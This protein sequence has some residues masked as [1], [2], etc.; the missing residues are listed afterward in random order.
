MADFDGIEEMH[1]IMDDDE[2]RWEFEAY[3]ADQ[4]PAIPSNQESSGST[5]TMTD[6]D[7]V[8]RNLDLDYDTIEKRLQIWKAG[9]QWTGTSMMDLSRSEFD[10]S[11]PWK[12]R[13]T[14]AKM[15]TYDVQELGPLIQCPKGGMT[16]MVDDI[17]SM[18]FGI[19]AYAINYHM[20][21]WSSF[22]HSDSTFNKSGI[23]QNVR[24]DIPMASGY[25]ERAGMMT[26]V[27]QT[28]ATV[29]GLERG[30]G[31]AKWY[32]LIVPGGSGTLRAINFLTKVCLDWAPSNRRN[33]RNRSSFNPR[34]DVLIDFGQ[35]HA[36]MMFAI[37]SLEAKGARV[38][39]PLRS[40]LQD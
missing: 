14:A 32:I 24:Y 8:D 21:A 18:V 19:S 16:L 40:R 5:G 1:R 17:N 12:N 29:E 26:A 31:L 35:L 9:G 38:L 39:L 7:G 2:L 13:E 10:A 30:R 25:Q 15:R 28:L 37:E 6:S 36:N 33:R 22:V 27:H 34:A 20:A 11:P 4:G 3:Q 23:L